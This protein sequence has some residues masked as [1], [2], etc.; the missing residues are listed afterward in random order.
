MNDQQ[1]VFEIFDVRKHTTRVVTFR[2]VLR[3]TH[4]AFRVVRVVQRPVCDWRARHSG[5][6]NTGILHHGVQRHVAAVAPAVD[7][8]PVAVDVVEPLEELGAHEL[9][10]DFRAPHAA[11]D[12]RIK[13]DAAE[14]R[15]AIVERKD[16][17][18]PVRHDVFERAAPALGNTLA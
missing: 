12:R 5:C 17:V 4:K 9:V 18:A 1:G 14:T 2:V 3:R 10:A 15:T 6:V 8:D 11:I 7:A 13:L 16:D